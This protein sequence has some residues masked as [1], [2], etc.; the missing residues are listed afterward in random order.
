VSW[1]SERSRTGAVDEIPL[2]HTSG[3]LWLA[4]K[5]FVGPDPEAALARVDGDVVVCLNE[6]HELD[7]RYPAYVAWLR[8]NEPGRAL[9]WPVPDLHAPGLDEAR[10]LLGLLRARLDDGATLL[11]HCGAGIGRAGTTAVGVLLSLGM[12]L[13]DALDVVAAHRPMAGPEVGAQ[14][15]L[16]EALAEQEAW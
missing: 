1:P 5:H 6:E 8:A 9:W 14:R 15:D 16:V 2:P 13:H 11:V 3:R 10:R 7:D 12:S 4:G